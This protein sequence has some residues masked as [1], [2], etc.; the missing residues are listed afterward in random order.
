MLDAQVCRNE[1]CEIEEVH[2]ISLCRK[3][4]RGGVLQPPL[5]IS[6]RP[7]WLKD[8]PEGLQESVRRAVPK[9]LPTNFSAIVDKVTND[10]GNVTERTVYRHV[11]RLVERGELLKL[12]LRLGFAAYARPTSKLVSDFAGMREI[13]TGIVDIEPDAS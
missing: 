13:M 7:A 1:E 11:R 4:R 8:D 2:T 6:K 12:N 9:T 5:K 3:D 10:Y